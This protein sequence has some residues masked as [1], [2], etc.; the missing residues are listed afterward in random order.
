MVN[1]SSDKNPVNFDFYA[2]EYEKILDSTISLSGEKGDYFQ[3]YKLSCIK[4]WVGELNHK[5]QI[6]DFGCGIGNLTGLLAKAYTKSKVYGYEISDK[7]VKLA[8]EKWNY[9]K[10]LTFTSQLWKREKYDLITVSNV[11]HHIKVM[12]RIKTLNQLG[13]LLKENGK[14]VI[15]QH[16]P[17][18]PLTRY[19]VKTCS[20]DTDAELISL[21]KFTHLVQNC[22]LNV[23]LSR[24]IVFFPNILRSLRKFEPWF[25]FLPLGAQYMLIVNRCQ[26]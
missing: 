5:G 4:R 2:S 19:A 10:N 15:F 18:N 8:N 25:G 21:S 7:S 17:Y 9:L 16:N 26:I 11:F 6:L 12:D 24:Y 20:F 14:I 3:E 1:K 13:S 22:K 23:L